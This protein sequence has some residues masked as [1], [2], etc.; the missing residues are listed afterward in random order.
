VYPALLGPGT[1]A[2]VVCGAPTVTAPL[3]S[4]AK[5]RQ[6]P[7]SLI[8]GTVL[9]Y[10][11]TK[12]PEHALCIGASVVDQPVDV[13][14]FLSLPPAP[15][16][17]LQATLGW[18]DATPWPSSAFGTTYTSVTA[19]ATS[20]QFTV[21][22]ATAPTPFVSHISWIS[23]LNWQI[24]SATVI[25]FTG[26]P[27]AYVITI[28]TP[29]PG[30]AP[31]NFIFPTSVNEATYLAALLGAFATMGPGE[32]F[33][34]GKDALK[35]ACRHP[36]PVLNNPAALDAVQLKQVINSGPEVQDAQWIY[37]S[38]TTPTVPSTITVDVNGNLTSAAPNI[39]TPRNIAFMGS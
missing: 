36:I 13:A 39:L 27:G 22:A 21:N 7:Q 29:M 3:E 38:A 23:P 16:T 15:S 25:A 1:A 12:F 17:P 33:A 26:A 20:M 10:V 30:I 37:R 35:R 4:N 18:L 6:L 28:D 24:Y 34:P 11:L 19:F 14:I 2:F 32:W 9:P 31:G 5:S 8:S